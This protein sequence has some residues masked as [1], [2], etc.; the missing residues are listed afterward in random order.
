M[1]P[2][3]LRIALLAS[4]ATVAATG[5]LAAQADV[6]RGR[7]TTAAENLP[8]LGA[9]VTA[10]SISGNV[11]RSA[12]TN[13]NGQY[14]ITFPNG[15]GDYWIS[16][17]AIGYSQRRYELKR[18]ADEEVLIADARLSGLTLDT[19]QVTVDRRRPSRN[20]NDRDVSGTERPVNPNLVSPD[21]A[22]DLA[23][24]AAS[25][26]GVT[27]IPGTNGDPS[28]FSVLGLSTDQNL[29]TL[30]GL[31][32]GASDLPR[33]AGAAVSV[34]TSPY[35][36]SQGGFSGGAL[37]VRTLPGSNY[38]EQGLS[39][40]GNLPQLEWT[41]LAGRSLGQRYA[42]LSLG[43]RLAGPLSYDKA[44][45]NFAWQLGRRGS[46]LPTLLNTDPL[47][48]QTIGVAPDSVTHLLNILQGFGMP[49]TTPGFPTSRLSDQGSLLGSLDFMP[50]SSSSGQA[51]NVTVN[52]GWNRVAPGSPLTTQ[53]P[54]TSS[55]FTNWSGSARLRHTAYI[56]GLI[57]TETGLALSTSHRTLT[58]YLDEPGGSVLVHSDFADGSSSVLPIQ[59]GGLSAV[60]T[61]RSGSQ[62]L[63]NQLSWFSGNNH[64]RLKLTSEL[65]HDDWSLE[66]AGNLLGSFVFNQLA[67]LAAGT[68]AQFSRQFAPVSASG[69]QI[70]GSVALGDAWRPNTDLQ[71]VYG[72]RLDAN[73]YLDRPASNPAVLAAL[74]VANAAVPNGTYL[75]PRIGLSWTYGTA[76][77]IGA[78]T[79][80]ARIPRAVVRAG[81]GVFQNTPGAQL[82]A[83]AMTNTG[84]AN[85]VQQLTC[86]GPAA[87]TPDWA[88]YAADPSTIPTSC[89]NGAPPS[90]GNA[91]P[92]VSLF[93]PDYAA[94]RSLRSTLQW[95]GPVIDN[96]F[97]ATVTGTWS[98]NNNQ[99][100]TLDLNF[101]PTVRFTLPGEAGRPV[102][103]QPAEI[104][105]ATGAVSSS[106]SRVAS[107]FNH[108]TESL[109]DFH[110]LSRQLEIQ[111]AP[112]AVNSSF[113]WGVA[114]TLNAVRDRAS[115]FSSTDGNP[116]IASLARAS[117]DWR[118]QI[119]VNVGANVFDLLRVNYLQRF[120]SG[121]PFTPV[122]SGDIN[123]DGYA[124]DRAF[125]ANPSGTA[126]TALAVGMAQLLAG[127]APRVRDCLTSQFGRI[128]GRNSCQGPWSSSGFLTIAFNP[129]RVRLPQRATLSLQIANP[130]GALDLALHGEAHMRGWGQAPVP[131]SRLLFVRGFDSTTDRYRYD[132]NQRFGATAQSVS[133]F[134]NPVAL[135]LSLSFDL[136]PTR[137]RQNLTQTLDRGR[138]LSGSKTPTPI[139]RAMY[140]SGGLINP[141]AA[142]LSQADSLQLTGPQADSLATM[143][144]WY[145]VHL[146][147]IWTPIIRGYGALADR[148]DHD[149]VY[150]NYRRA[151]EGTVDLLVKLAPEVSGLLS[152]SQRR[153]LPPLVAAYL[154]RRYLAAIRSSTSG[155]PGGVFAPG[156]GVP[157][158]MG[159]MG[160]GQT[161]IIRN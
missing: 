101:D 33:D 25:Q 81:I 134:R 149:D 15:D 129:L 78:F 22:G 85:G 79:G 158:G 93:A 8:I 17:A 94:Q 160:G 100:G 82:I 43:G 68:P 4:A 14:T 63:T 55:R 144:R 159:A 13:S 28:G 39:A 20:D 120:T 119:Q 26:P 130:L 95:A 19:V 135:T 145:I 58:P 124:N 18:I 34:A 65:R 74:G 70:V 61:S 157:G 45:Y 76:S 123:G 77:Q 104:A 132:V 7:V 54:T 99:S 133:A 142:M 57:L 56:G 69:G 161:I 113:S 107:Q 136:G 155:S 48:L 46:D 114:Y 16:F 147:S 52:G 32:S 51:L 90:F 84:L 21:Q 49:V 59:F 5:A 27:L 60:N 37:N 50:P 6:I 108:V 47:G 153:K 125:I 139:L 96:R 12:K 38:I 121:T 24:M 122:V 44:F 53:L 67:D 40:I 140:G 137:E 117:G 91:Q 106:G 75:S 42:N 97:M 112:L 9:I 126:D 105:A 80:A 128:A 111:I 116:L 156:A 102:F 1:I 127:A 23:A 11:S 31:A 72:V 62:Q 35:D 151:R 131:D 148:Y 89:A 86:I 87:P 141:L 98:R 2:T 152:P 92:N 3:S 146:D 115:G 118:H 154:D 64:H 30:N 143:N 66:Q 41:D 71:I 103:V 29:T 83:Q 73:H 138:T 88:G 10:T 109:S 150:R 110:S 36:V